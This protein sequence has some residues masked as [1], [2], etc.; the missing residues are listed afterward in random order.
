MDVPVHIYGQ[1]LAAA[2]VSAKP[3]ANYDDLELC[4]YRSRPVK[5]KGADAARSISGLAHLTRPQGPIWGLRE[6]AQSLE[7]NTVKPL[8]TTMTSGCPQALQKGSE[9]RLIQSSL[10]VE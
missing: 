3:M 1:T 2:A 8:E 4:M 9:E 6:R 10:A 5:C 7:T